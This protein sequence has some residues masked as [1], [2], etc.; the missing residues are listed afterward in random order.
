VDKESSDLLEINGLA[1]ILSP[2]SKPA[3]AGSAGDSLLF[4]DRMNLSA[5][6]FRGK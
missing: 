4:S 2:A 3:W 5:T 1:G 6:L